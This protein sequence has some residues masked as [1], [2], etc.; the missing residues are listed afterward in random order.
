MITFKYRDFC[1]TLNKSAILYILSGMSSIKKDEL[2]QVSRFKQKHFDNLKEERGRSNNMMTSIVASGGSNINLSTLERSR[3]IWIN[4]TLDYTLISIVTSCGSIDINARTLVSIGNKLEK[5]EENFKKFIAAYDFVHYIDSKLNDSDSIT[6]DF[7]LEKD[8]KDFYDFIKDDVRNR[9]TYITKT[10]TLKGIDNLELSDY[11]I[12]YSQ[13]DG[14]Y[15]QSN[16]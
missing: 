12:Y 14:K 8:L 5:F 9:R 16:N 10:V 11:L 4:A 7:N 3:Q 13:N 15:I 6:I 1:F 2:A